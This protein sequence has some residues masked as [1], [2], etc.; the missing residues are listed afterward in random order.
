MDSLTPSLRLRLVTVEWVPCLSFEAVAPHEP[1]QAERQ[2]P[3]KWWDLSTA[4]KAAL[5]YNWSGAREGPC[6]LRWR[7][8]GAHYEPVSLTRQ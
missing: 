8:Y 1:G 5:Q 6:G 3:R 7:G 2:L 4:T